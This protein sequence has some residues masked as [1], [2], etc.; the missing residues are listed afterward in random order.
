[1]S[2]RTKNPLKAALAVAICLIVSMSAL[3]ILL[4]RLLSEE[5][6]SLHLEGE[7][8]ATIS[9]VITLHC[10]LTNRSL[11]LFRITHYPQIIR[12]SINGA[13]DTVASSAESDLM[14]PFRS[15]DRD[16]SLSFGVPG[17]YEVIVFSDFTVSLFGKM[18]K[19]IHLQT[20]LTINVE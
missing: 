17:T 9:E 5:S 2:K 18:E 15:F 14:Y 10:N 7:E 4:F 20:T 8:S 6:F 19:Q 1:M 11:R 13:E 12:Y 3:S 16:I